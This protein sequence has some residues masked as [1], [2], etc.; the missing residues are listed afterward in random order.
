MRIDNPSISG[1]IS[2][3]RGTNS[4]SATSVNLTGSLSGTFE[5]SFSTAATANISGAFNSVSA[6]I[7]QN[8]ETR[9]KNTTDTLDGDLTVT[10]TITAQEFH[11][12]FVSAS[13]IYQSG[14]TQFG[15]STDD[16]H[17]FTGTGSFDKVGI[18]TTTPTQILQVVENGGIFSINPTVGGVDLHSN[19]NF[20]PHYQTN[21]DWYTGEMGSGTFRMRLNSNGNL[22]IGTTS[23]AGDLEISGSRTITFNPGFNDHISISSM[24][25]SA[26]GFNAFTLGE[27]NTQNNSAAIRFAYSS[28]GSTSNYLGLGFY[29][30][31]DKVTIKADGNVGIGTNSPLTALHLHTGAAGTG[32]TGSFQDNTALGIESTS[33][34]YIEMLTSGGS[35]GQMQGILFSDNGRNA[36]V[37]YK[38]F[39][40]QVADTKGEALHLAFYDFSATD[41]N[42]GIYFGTSNTPWLGVDTTH[43]FIKGNGNV[44]IGTTSPGS[45]F[46]VNGYTTIG[47]YGAPHYT[48]SGMAYQV[49]RATTDN[50]ARAL[51]ELHSGN[52]L[53]KA[54]VQAV[55]ANNT[56]YFGAL[57]N[58]NASYGNDVSAFYFNT[59]GNV[60]LGTTNN[61]HKLVVKGTSAALTSDTAM[62]FYI[63]RASASS[64][65][66]I[67]FTTGGA[68]VS[69]GWAEIGQT[70]ANGDLYFKAN[71]S[72]ASYNSRMVIKGADGNVGIG[73]DTPDQK[74]EVLGNAHIDYS[75]LGRGIRDTDRGEF[76]LNATG[77]T[78]VSEIFFGY[79]NGYVENNIRWGI[80]D[81]G[82]GDDTL[83]FYKGP[84]HS[85]WA[86][87]FVLK[88]TGNQAH[89]YGNVGIGITSP[90]Q[91]LDVSG[92]IKFGTWT[93][94]GS[95]YIGFGRNDTGAFGTG[96]ASG[97]EIESVVGSGNGT[98]DQNVHLWT[99]WYNN[100][101]DR[102]L[103]ATWNRRVGIGQT[104][105]QE[106]L[107]VAG[108]IKLQ[109]TTGSTASPNYIHL[110]NNYSNGA[111]RDKLK[112]YLYNSGTEQYGFGVGAN[113]DIQYHSNLRHDFYIANTHALQIDS[114][115]DLRRKAIYKS[116][117]WNWLTTP[118]HYYVATTSQSSVTLDVSADFTLNGNSALPAD[119]KAL[120]VTYYYHISGYGIGSAG[121]GD[122]ANDIWG[123]DAPGT[124][125]SWSFTTSGNYDWGSAVF[126]HDGD[127]SETGDMGYYGVWH[128]GAI[129]PVNSNGNIYGLLSHGW[130]GGTHYHHMYVWGYSI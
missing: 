5:G 80:S 3:L 110:G 95:R 33:D 27:A 90:N 1:S 106:K 18:G 29:A 54:N 125:T 77:A 104:N 113:G 34:Q 59:A 61:T 13:I 69:N 38:E 87:V 112:I 37:G 12:E 39:T 122:H 40:G 19:A 120:Y 130:S 89:F 98:Y 103:T 124:T 11:T 79:G 58:S 119:T 99:H 32:A 52:Q 10:G 128:P 83:R 47:R 70:D 2:F 107:D 55:G 74:L 92:N 117:Q 26:T 71:V 94:A 96:G 101:S 25:V 121:Q 97:L 64:V 63:D 24:R 67:I 28:A 51:L 60:G 41:S 6:S 14:S 9:L 81:R 16:T 62:R 68:S 23:P 44:G 129:I 66:S 76:H 93:T 88:A 126:M 118:M 114:N 36:F 17:V 46:H 116:A 65:G 109:S 31:D 123:P 35:S 45:K 48:Q 15:N 111:T 82:T 20:A 127:S 115:G 56:V 43:M 21:F 8:V 85:G 86:E 100:G 105:P 50:S 72:A 84:A 102:T 78:D 57:T 22:G 73:I 108:N 49:I 42:N 53:V 75:V 4:I 30:N 7:A 91:A